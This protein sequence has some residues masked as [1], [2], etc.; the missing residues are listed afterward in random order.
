MCK[1]QPD[2][3]MVR[4]DRPAGNVPDRLFWPRFRSRRVT[5][6]DKLWGTAPTKSFPWR[7]RLLRTS[8]NASGEGEHIGAH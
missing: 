3:K 5:T 8:Q 4:V 7:A 2:L 1:G 6:L